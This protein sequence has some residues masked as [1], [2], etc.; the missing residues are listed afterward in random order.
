[1]AGGGGSTGVGELGTCALGSPRNLGGPELSVEKPE[2]G[3]PEPSPGPR[4]SCSCPQ[5]RRQST[6]AVP[7]S[8]GN[9]A[10]REGARDVGASRNTNETGEPGR[11]DP[12]EGRGRHDEESRERTMPETLSSISISTKLAWI[13]ELAERKRSSALTTLAHHLDETWLREAFRR[14]RKGGAVGVDGQSALQY[15]EH[16]DENV[17]ALLDRAKSGRYQA[18]P[19]RRVHIPK[20]DGRKTRPIGIPTFEDKVLQR[21]VAMV[22]EPVYEQDF[23]PCSYGFRSRRSAH[24]A[25]AEL[26]HAVMEIRGGWVLE[27]DIERFF[28][29]ID[30]A[31]LMAI[32]RQRIQDGVLLRLIS[33][34]L[35][36]GVL[37]DGAVTL[38]EVGTPQGGVISPLLANI[39]LHEV[40]DAWF[41]RDVAPRLCGRATLIRYADDAVIVFE[42]EADARRVLAVLGKR[43]AKY[44]LALHPEK[45]R[46]VEFRRPL[47]SV[48]RAKPRACFDLLGFTHYWAKSRSGNWVVKRKTAKDRFTR[49]V[50]RVAEWCWTHR[51]QPLVAQHDALSRKLKGHYAYFGI[52]GNAGALSRFRFE[53]DRLWHKWLSRRSGRARIP[54]ERWQRLSKQYPLPEPRV[55]RAVM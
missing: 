51:H 14:T 47:L 45:T 44:G 6:A 9:E 31:K 52:A 46:L 33:K 39:Y 11:R 53:V 21:A 35:H 26:W 37:E 22:L 15:E 36:A 34:W 13:A 23:L 2:E 1:M 20:G 43:F 27:I 17:R 25:L 24:Q 16:L 40:L 48:R 18:P 55:R 19:V 50:R 8:E 5:E 7:P 4:E 32:V 54:W 42:S 29:T 38:P 30:H 28:D 12:A 3:D 41:G 10:R 49:S